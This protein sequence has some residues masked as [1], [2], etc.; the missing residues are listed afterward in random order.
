MIG[1]APRH[2]SG[3]IGPPSASSSGRASAYE[4]GRTGIFVSVGASVTREA[5]RVR[6]RA[7]AGRQ[8]VARI[9]RHVGHGA[10]LRAPIVRN[11]PFGY[12]SPWK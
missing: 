2:A 9:K 4:I 10:A 1:S 5:L 3:A 12:A 6:R 7:D 8:R 11:A